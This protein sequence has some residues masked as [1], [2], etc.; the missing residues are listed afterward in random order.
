MNHCN[1]R[2]VAGVLLGL[3]GALIIL[4]PGF[5]EISA[6]QL[7]QLIAAPLFA[8]SYLLTKKFT[9][10]SSPEEIVGWLSLFCA[11]TLLPGA[12]LEWQTP[13]MHDVA[14]LGVVAVLATLGHFALTKALAAAPITVTQPITFLQLVWATILGV[15]FFGEALDIYVLV[16]GGVIVAAAT[17]ISHREAVAARQQYTPPAAATKF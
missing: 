6:G 16:G 17:Y 9:F 12:V 8:V 13:S 1:F 3:L 7:A 15:G 14:W 10:K 5:E 2:R 11:L 4:R